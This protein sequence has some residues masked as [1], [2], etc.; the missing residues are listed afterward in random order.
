MQEGAS[1]TGGVDEP[2]VG[3]ALP[4]GVEA[5]VFARAAQPQGDEGFKSSIQA[6]GG[7]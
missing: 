6:V 1:P 4:E 3:A 5:S 2:A 7:Q